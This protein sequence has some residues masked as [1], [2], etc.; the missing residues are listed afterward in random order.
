MIQVE[1]T[2]NPNSLKFLS[3]QTISAV[4]TEEFQKKEI[5]NIKNIFVKE[6]LSLKGVELILLAD[7][8]LSV[9]KNDEVSWEILKP[10][11]ISHINDYF[12]KNKTPILKKKSNEDNIVD[13][14]EG[15]ISKIKDVLDTKI[16][17]AVARDGGDIKF[18]SYENGVVKVE[19]Q[20][21]CSGCPSSV[22]TLKQG[23]QNLLK[24]YVKEV[25]SVEAI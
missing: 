6:L 20:G 10:M 4:G 12:E 3:E 11:V 14:E 24:H 2:P 1:Q 18:R 16:R 17:P 25:E 7:N 22:V 15:T 23:V 5:K 13:E 8:F 9:K 19:L 21:S